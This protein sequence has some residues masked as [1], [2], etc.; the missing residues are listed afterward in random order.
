[1]VRLSSERAL[2]PRFEKWQYWMPLFGRLGRLDRLAV[3]SQALRRNPA[4]PR[5]DRGD[6]AAFSLAPIAD[7][8]EALRLLEHVAK[9]A[10]ANRRTQALRPWF[11][12]QVRA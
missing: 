9:V 11:A 10:P 2:D 8:D 1:P 12:A 5:R 7:P 3:W 6:G 4:L